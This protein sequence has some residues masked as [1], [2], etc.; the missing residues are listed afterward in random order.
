MGILD[1]ATEASVR[2]TFEQEVMPDRCTVNR[3]ATAGDG[4]GGWTGDPAVFA[5]GIPCR[6]DKD[7]TMDREA[8]IAGRQITASAYII[9]LSMVAARW[10][11][12]VVDVRTG[13]QL[14][15]TGSGAGTFEVISS[16]GP[17][18]DEFTRIVRATK[19]E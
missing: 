14:I 13:D 16:G 19:V 2:A 9:T 1:A 11:G 18:T 6:V 17:S 7:Q 10:P 8:I 12:G 4:A 5:A 15:V 3:Y